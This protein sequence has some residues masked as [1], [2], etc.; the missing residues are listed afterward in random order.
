MHEKDYPAAETSFRRAVE[1]NRTLIRLE[2]K[3][4]RWEKELATTLLNLGALQHLQKDYAGAEPFLREAVALRQG[5]VD[6]DPKSARN[7]RKLA[8]ARHRLA[9]FQF[10]TGRTNEA[11]A[12][13][14]SALAAFRRLL[15]TDPD[16]R[17]AIE[18]IQQ[19]TEKYRDRLVAAAM[20]A[21]ARELVRD[22]AAFAE[23]NRTGKPGADA[24]DQLLA[25]LRAAS[26]SL[27][28]APP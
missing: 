10:D 27:P 24:W 11:L 19:Y 8:H 13:G 17:E 4:R 28:A 1:P 5:L 2:P 7:L 12:S 15:T 3:N 23:A 9:L 16:D 20:I 26:A 22:T 18:E 14:Q 21:E 6:W 25:S